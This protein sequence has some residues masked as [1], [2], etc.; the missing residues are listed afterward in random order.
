[1]CKRCLVMFVLFMAATFVAVFFIVRSV[2][3]QAPP[4]VMNEIAWMGTALSANDEWIELYNTGPI[5][6]DLSGWTLS[7]EDG[8]PAITLTGSIGAGEYFLLER[9]DESSVAAVSADIIYTGSLS[10]SGEL[11]RLSDSSGAPVHSVS[12][13]LAGDNKTKQTM[14]R[15]ASGTWRNGVSG[16]TPKAANAFSPVVPSPVTKKLS[17]LAA[18]PSTQPSGQNKTASAEIGS[19]LAQKQSAPAMVAQQNAFNTEA[20]VLLS[21]AAL[22]SAA[23]GGAITYLRSHRPWA[24]E[25]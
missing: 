2:R 12:G 17:A 4:V 16:G 7:A 22:T 23:A 10:N 8:S 6:I 11:L 1:M 18:Q 13:W 25:K 14:A 15:T 3:G 21:I 9:T 24:S 5:A 20:L 19:V